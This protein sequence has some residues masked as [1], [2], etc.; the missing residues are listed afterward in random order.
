MRNNQLEPGATVLLLVILGV[1]ILSGFIAT[2]QA[3]RSI[4]IPAS[5]LSTPRSSHR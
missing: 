3:K 1:L 5:M 4:N 2:A